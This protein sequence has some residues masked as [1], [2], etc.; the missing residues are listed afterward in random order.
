MKV[1]RRIA[2]KQ[3][4]VISA[5]AVLAP[6]CS[7]GKGPSRLFKNIKA[8]E[9]HD[10]LITALADTILPK[11]STPGAVELKVPEFMAKMI[12][13]CMKEED[14][15][16]WLGGANKFDAEIQESA[17]KLFSDLNAEERLKVLTEWE[18]NDHSDDEL[19]VFYKTTRSLAIRGYTSSGYFM[20]TIQHYNI[21]PGAFKGCISI[22]NPS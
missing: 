17:G 8:T 4:A 11:S 7:T 12:D 16:K 1:N 3:L 21:I 6:S 18:T 19:K 13:D 9:D 14:Q 2:I 22:N 20:T 10:S 15:I 5:V